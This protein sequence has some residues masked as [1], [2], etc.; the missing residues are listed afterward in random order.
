MIF[1]TSFHINA[2]KVFNNPKNTC[3]SLNINMEIYGN[4]FTKS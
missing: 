4:I 3:N 2:K 1:S